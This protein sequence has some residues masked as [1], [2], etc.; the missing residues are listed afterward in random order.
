L[1]LAMC[2]VDDLGALHGII[3]KINKR[4]AN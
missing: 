1:E 3:Q 4:A 2:F